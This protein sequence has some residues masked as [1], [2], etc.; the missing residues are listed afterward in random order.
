MITEE[1]NHRETCGVKDGVH[2]CPHTSPV[3]AQYLTEED[4]RHERIAQQHSPQ[5]QTGAVHRHGE[6]SEPQEEDRSVHQESF[7]PPDGVIE[8]ASEEG[9]GEV[10]QYPTAG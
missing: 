3:S 2:G 5:D 1:E 4:L 9:G 10:A 7:L 6:E 8:E